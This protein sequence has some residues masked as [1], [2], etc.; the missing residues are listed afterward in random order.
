MDIKEKA[1]YLRAATARMNPSNKEFV[2]SIL[3]AFYANRASEKQLAAIERKYEEITTAREKRTT[4][5]RL[6]RI[7]ALLNHALE[8][9]LK[10]P[11]I[12]LRLP[13][14]L[15]GI[16]V[17]VGDHKTEGKV[18]FVNDRDRLVPNKY[19]VEKPAY[20][21]YIRLSTGEL[22]KSPYAD[23]SLVASAQGTL[24]GFEADPHKA[25]AVEAHATGHCC[26][27]GLPLEDGR[28]V[29]MGYG[30]ICARK[31]G[32]PWGEGSNAENLFRVMHTFKDTVES[33]KESEEFPKI[34]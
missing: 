7:A 28:S 25:S 15:G 12:R 23:S 5:L 29:A 33:E 11:A 19:G 8:H 26:F 27:C 4:G 3:K 2:T 18:A 30:P 16:K 32:L 34:A 14:G 21:G 20:Y 9:G 24:E 22:V 10:K 1:D 17:R 31:W 13:E 6:P